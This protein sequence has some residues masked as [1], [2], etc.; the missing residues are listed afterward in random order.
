MIVEI[1]EGC[2]YE[3]DDEAMDNMELVEAIA[4]TKNDSASGLGKVLSILLGK[5]QKKK[6]YDDLRNEKGRVPVADVS[7]AIIKIMNSFGSKGKKS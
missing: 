3:I 4:E 2:K 7:D 6:L 1:K 5:E